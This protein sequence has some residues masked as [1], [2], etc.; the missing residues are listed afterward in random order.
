MSD[1][2][3]GNQDDVQASIDLLKKYKP[4]LGEK[5]Q[6]QGQ[7]L[8]RQNEI[9]EGAKGPVMSKFN[10]VLKKP[11][12]AANLAGQAVKGVKE[13]AVGRLTSPFIDNIQGLLES[14]APILGKYKEQLANAAARG[15]TAL[16]ASHYALSNSDPVY[17]QKV[18]E[19]NKRFNDDHDRTIEF[20]DPS[21]VT[22]G[23]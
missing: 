4:E 23:K 13:S 12:E 6:T 1:K 21:I 19:F 18:D 15:T 10:L 22:P 8:S 11:T 5:L 3:V 14:N 2:S 7:D 9:M 16:I 20:T 17:R